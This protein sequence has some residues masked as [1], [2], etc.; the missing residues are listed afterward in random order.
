[1][2]HRDRFF[3]LSQWLGVRTSL[4]FHI[5]TRKRVVFLSKKLVTFRFYRPGHYSEFIKRI[6]VSY[7]LNTVSLVVI[8]LACDAIGPEFDPGWMLQRFLQKNS[9][10]NT[11]RTSRPAQMSD[12]LRW[13]G[14]SS[15]NIPQLSMLRRTTNSEIIHPPD[16]VRNWP[17]GRFFL[18][19]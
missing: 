8:T 16:A 11:R 6:Y 12:H 19:K 17:R 9:C 3:G 14:S 15:S 18:E 5:R 2:S 4:K 10:G 7:Q 1:M 13:P